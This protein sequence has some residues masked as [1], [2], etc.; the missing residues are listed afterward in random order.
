MISAISN[1]TQTQPVAQPRAAAPRK[2]TP[3]EKPSAAPTDTVQLSKAAQ[4]RVAALQEARET[5]AQTA[6]EAGRGDIQA[7]RLLAKEATAKPV[8]K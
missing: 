4:A 3:S 7:K 2:P 5:A 8:T 6:Q 1:A